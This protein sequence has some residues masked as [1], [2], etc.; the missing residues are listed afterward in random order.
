MLVLAGCTASDDPSAVAAAPDISGPLES[1]LGSDAEMCMSVAADEDAV[2]GYTAEARAPLQLR[3]AE[4]SG[5][6]GL[7]VVEARAAEIPEDG[8]RTPTGISIWPLTGEDERWY[9]D[10][11][12]GA[13]VTGTVSIM[14]RVHKDPDRAEGDASGLVLRYVADGDEHV[15]SGTGTVRVAED[16]DGP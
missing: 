7:T 14:V 13:T 3:S 9:W 6:D 1:D 16:C 4:L 2:F 10:Q 5:A 12:E 11:G 15:V 8:S